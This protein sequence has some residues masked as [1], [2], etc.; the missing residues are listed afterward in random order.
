[1]TQEQLDKLYEDAQELIQIGNETEA[2]E[3][4]YYLAIKYELIY[5]EEWE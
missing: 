5:K 1:M 4:I 3:L 2:L